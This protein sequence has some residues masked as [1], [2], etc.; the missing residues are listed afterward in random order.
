MPGI[1]A[2]LI[3]RCDIHI[4]PRNFSRSHRLSE[5]I[6]NVSKAEISFLLE[7]YIIRPTKKENNPKKTRKNK[8]YFKN[9]QKIITLLSIFFSKI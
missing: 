5:I 3:Y 2:Q 7:I 1:M 6:S 9:T 4:S 8:F